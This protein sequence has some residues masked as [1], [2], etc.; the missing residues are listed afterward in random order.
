MALS[1]LTMV[2]GNYSAYWIGGDPLVVTDKDV[3][4]TGEVVRF[5]VT[6]YIPMSFSSGKQC[7]FTVEAASGDVVYDMSHHTSWVQVLTS[8]LPPKTFAFSWDQRN[9]TGQQV[10]AGEYKIWGY[11][12]GY[13]MSDPP[14]AGNST[15]I[16]IGSGPVPT[17]SVERFDLHLAQG[18]NLISLPLIATNYTSSNLGL[19]TGSVVASFS[20][21]SQSWD[22]FIVGVSPPSRSFP[23]LNFKGYFVF[24]AASQTLQMFG[25]L[26]TSY[27]IELLPGWNLVGFPKTSSGNV[28]HPSDLPAWIAPPVVGQIII[29]LFDPVTDTY[30][31]WISGLPQMNNFALMPGVGYAIY[32]GS[33]GAINI[34]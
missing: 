25:E 30:R 24:V 4:L 26:A 23:L 32:V 22:V 33:G 21:A 7:Y 28:Y 11:E 9:D 14:I 5:N 19:P 16:T 8:L 10:P 31:T 13:H 20:S 1:S 27:Q 17:Q 18:W 6:C 12:A 29:C 2:T 34:G 3:Y 15:S